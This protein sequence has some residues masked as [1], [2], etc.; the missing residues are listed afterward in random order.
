MRNVIETRPSRIRPLAAWTAVLVMALVATA[1]AACDKPAPAQTVGQKIDA[2]TTGIE[3]KA[4]QI[5]DD[6][7]ATTEA[8]MNKTEQAA[9]DVA[10]TV[11]DA[12][13]TT[14]VN[15]KIAQD[16]RLSAMSINVDTVNGRVVLRG[17]APDAAVSERA[18]QLAASVDGVV[19]VDNQ[20]VIAGKG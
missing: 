6:A 11:K 13:I 9:G 1:L 4:A 18:R 20:L 17:N 3:Q 7:K 15:A 8:A 14:A 19:S 12:A 2:A 10:N 16:Q 5:K